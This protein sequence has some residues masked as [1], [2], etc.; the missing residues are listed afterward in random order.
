MGVDSCALMLANPS[1]SLTSDGDV[2]MVVLGVLVGWDVGKGPPVAVDESVDP[3][4]DVVE[5]VEPE[6]SS[7]STTDASEPASEV[8]SAWVG[9]S[10]PGSLQATPP[11]A[12][13][14]SPKSTGASNA[15]PRLRR[16][17]DGR[18]LGTDEWS[19]MIDLVVPWPMAP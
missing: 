8:T 5:V 3:L 2:P 17:V 19:A 4:D 18:A 16:C 11:K 15:N 9:P 1:G 14:S 6:E 10:E 13:V 7:T 12:T